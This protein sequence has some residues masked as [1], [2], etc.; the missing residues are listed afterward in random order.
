MAIASTM[1]VGAEGINSSQFSLDIANASLSKLFSSSVRLCRFNSSPF[2]ATWLT[3]FPDLFDTV[4]SQDFFEPFPEL[5]KLKEEIA[6]QTAF[7][8]FCPDDWGAITIASLR[9][10][11][12]R[13]I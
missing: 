2:L 13:S 4:L 9:I 6:E 7:P 8:L 5:E 11:A 10:I 3:R 1:R 12:R